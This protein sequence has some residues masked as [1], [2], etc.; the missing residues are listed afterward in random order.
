MTTTCTFPLWSTTVSV[1]VEDESALSAATDEVRGVLHEIEMAASR[2]R[3]DSELS[4]LR[5]G[6]NHI[7][8]M[9]ADLVGKALDVAR[10]TG[11][12]VDPTV[13]LSLRALGYDRSIERVDPDGPAVTL[14]PAV[15]GWET[16]QLIDRRLAVPKGVL[17]DLGATA[18]AA[19]ADL[20]AARA[21]ERVGTPVLVSVGG[22]IA[23]AGPGPG[24]GWQV[25]VQDSEDEPACQVTL[26]PGAAIATSST[27]RRAWNRGGQT[28]HHIVDP[29]R[30]A[31][32][33]PVWRA[34]TVAAPTCL[35]ANAAST[36]AIVLGQHA[37][38]W[39][40]GRGLSARLVDRLHRV[41]RLGSWP[42]EAA[43]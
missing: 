35:E 43:A 4:R 34:V 25:L 32:A 3:E 36:A 10:D 19:A 30:A 40:G 39:L 2:F 5:P 38:T 28:L 41:V 16:V 7:S 1:V 27:V 15:P 24:R 33:V 6:A 26:T 37:P 29:R 23:T 13:G 22:D 9:L 18:K 17:L 31:P 20:A 11:G 8:P 14:V 42:K 12:L 21:A